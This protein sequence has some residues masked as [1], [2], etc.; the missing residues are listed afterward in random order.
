MDFSRPY[1]ISEIATLTQS[2]ILGFANILITGNGV[3]G[4][5]TQV[6]ITSSQSINVNCN[7]ANGFTV[8]GGPSN[9][10]YSFNNSTPRGYMIDERPNPVVPCICNTKNISSVTISF[11]D[12]NNNLINFN[13][14]QFTVRL[15]I[16]QI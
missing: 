11:T 2:E 9:V 15:V 13:G 8:N 4:S 5:S 1:S 16:Q 6:N 3:Y 12:E 7:V 10:V 14:E